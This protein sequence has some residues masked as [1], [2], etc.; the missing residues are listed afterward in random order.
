MMYN[1]SNYKGLIGMVTLT[2]NE[3]ESLR[4]FIGP[5]KRYLQSSDGRRE[6]E[7]RKQQTRF[8]REELPGR[9]ADLAETDVAEIVSRLWSTQLW[10][11]KHRMFSAVEAAEKALIYRSL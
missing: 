6:N 1:G 8:F 10:G 5:F 7:E 4:K 2:A 11:N 9:L 3:R